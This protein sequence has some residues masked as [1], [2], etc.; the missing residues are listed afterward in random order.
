[1]IWEI[2]CGLWTMPSSPSSLRGF[3]GQHGR[4]IKNSEMMKRF[5][6]SLKMNNSGY[7]D[8]YYHDEIIPNMRCSKCGES[9]ISKGG[10]ITKTPTRYPEGFQI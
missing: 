8:R 9:T 3:P 5:T 2:K 6:K 4:T 1:M 10:E 7:D